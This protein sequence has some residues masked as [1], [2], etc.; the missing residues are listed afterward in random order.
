MFFAKNWF[1]AFW[2]HNAYD[3]QHLKIFLALLILNV[4]NRTFSYIMFPTSRYVKQFINVYI[5]VN[6]RNRYYYITQR[7]FKYIVAQSVA[8]GR[9]NTKA[10]DTES[11][12]AATHLCCV[13][14]VSCTRQNI[15]WAGLWLQRLCIHPK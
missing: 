5:F 10:T 3:Y 12:T 7:Y 4:T 8:C 6:V 11:N 15:A 14:P 9:D 2:G 1:H 13:L